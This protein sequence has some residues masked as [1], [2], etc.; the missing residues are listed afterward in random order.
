MNILE[1]VDYLFQFI[2]TKMLILKDLKLK[3]FFRVKR[4]FILVYLNQDADLKSFKAKKYYL[5]KGI[6]ENY[7][8]INNGKNFY[9][10]PLDS[11]IKRYEGIRKFTT[12]QGEDYTTGCLLIRL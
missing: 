3:I 1:S 7:N 8:V 5:P 11:D 12:A 6:I 2:Q 10:Q 4:L 9:G